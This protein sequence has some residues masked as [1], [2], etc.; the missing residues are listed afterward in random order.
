MEV[1][2]M[3]WMKTIRKDKLCIRIYDNRQELGF[4][5]S[6]DVAEKIREVLKTKREANL[7]FAS[8]PS[9]NEFLQG[10]LKD[11]TIPWDKVNAFHMDEYIG[12]H[13]DA[14]QGFGNFIRER[15]WGRVPLKS[16]HFL[17]G[18]AA[19]AEAEC[20]RY[21][22]LL[23]KYPVDIVCLGIGENGHIAFNDPP[24][25]DF[26]DPKSVKVVR[27]ETACRQQQVND[28]CFSSLSEVPTHALT[29]TIPALMKGKHL[30]TI[31]PGKTKMEAVYHTFAD[32][33]GTQCPATI[34]RTHDDVILYVDA[35]SAALIPGFPF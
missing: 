12:L 20:L 28:G 23:E 1:W 32:A 6:L 8:A 29:L 3:E 4:D 7:I 27:L 24:V 26:H 31:V 13:R 5:A 30:F 21:T 34:L 17:D 11:G 22:E 2:G 19:D 14:P 9:Q 15:L 25:A 10:L 16:A 18:N 33:V 35:D